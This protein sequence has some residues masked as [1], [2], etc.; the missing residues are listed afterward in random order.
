[1][2][3]ND[4]KSSARNIITLYSN[5]ARI[6]NSIGEN[7]NFF[8]LDYLSSDLAPNVDFDVTTTVLAS[9]RY[10]MRAEQTE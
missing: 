8:H 3:T 4:I 1:M 9:L 7:V 10:R 2:L 5:R 6:E